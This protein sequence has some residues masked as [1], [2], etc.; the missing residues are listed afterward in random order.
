MC[1]S[2]LYNAPTMLPSGGR[3]ATSSMHY[4]TSRNTQSSSPEDGHNNCQKHIERTGIIKKPLLLHLVFCVYYLYC[5]R[6]GGCEL[7][8]ATTL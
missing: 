6:Y 2:M 4:T 7:T 3:P 8:D 1:Y 5:G